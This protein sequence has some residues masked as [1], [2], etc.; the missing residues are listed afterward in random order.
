MRFVE[1]TL[2]SASQIGDTHAMKANATPLE[3]VRDHLPYELDMLAGTFAK[4]EQG[5]ADT[6]VRNALIESFCIHARSLIDFFNNEQ[7]VHASV[8]TADSYVPFSQ[9]KIRSVLSEKLNT[10]IAHLTLRRT[11]DSARKI[12]DVAR[13]ELLDGLASALRDFTQHLK[14]E[15][16][17]LWNHATALDPPAVPHAQEP[18]ATNAVI[19]THTDGADRA[20]VRWAA[21][22]TSPSP[23]VP[24]T[25]SP[26][27]G[28]YKMDPKKG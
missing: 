1:R 5:A 13:R 16:A 18:S 21:T 17:A 19:I 20:A 11:S 9:G 14:P 8:F 22:T 27:E 6:I 3:I 28:I 15:Y 23:F 7:G 26:Q 12:D 25:I 4:L 2:P 24:N 10:Q